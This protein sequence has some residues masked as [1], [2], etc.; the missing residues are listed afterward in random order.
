M[1]TNLVYLRSR[2]YAR[3]RPATLGTLR[4]MFEAILFM[5]VIVALVVVFQAFV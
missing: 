2:N 1:V 5:L 3:T 4:T